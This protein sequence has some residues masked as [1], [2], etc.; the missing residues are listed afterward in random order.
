MMAE[1][2]RQEEKYDGGRD[3]LRTGAR[4]RERSRNRVER[5]P[6]RGAAGGRAAFPS[7]GAAAA[8]D[9]GRGC[10]HFRTGLPAVDAA[11]YEARFGRAAGRRLPAAEYLGTRRR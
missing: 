10:H 7:A 5:Y 2:P 9:R 11:E 3:D 8:V 6:V 1:V 4:C